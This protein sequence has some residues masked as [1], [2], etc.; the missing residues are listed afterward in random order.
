MLLCKQDVM[1]IDIRNV[2]VEEL[3]R[4]F[5]Q[6]LLEDSRFISLPIQQFTLSVASG[7]SE[8]ATVTW[9]NQQ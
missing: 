9:S 4:W 8:H 7:P 1:L 2:T 6:Q 5:M 3:A